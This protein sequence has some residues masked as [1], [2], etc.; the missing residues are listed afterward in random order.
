MGLDV[1][2]LAAAKK[3]TAQSLDGSGALQGQKGDPGK[4]G[5]D[6][7]II[8]NISVDEN[9]VL[10]TT[11]SDGT[12]LPSGT[13]QTVVGKDGVDGKDGIDGTNGTDGQDGITPHIDPVTKH[14]F[15]GT[16]DTGIVAEGKDGQDGQQGIPG[17]QGTPGVPGQQ[18]VQG[19]KGDKGDDGYPFLIYKEYADVSEFSEDD[20]PKIGLLFMIKVEDTTSFPV[21]RYTGE[22]ENPYSFVTNLSGSEGIK[23]DKGDPGKD[24]EQGIPGQAGAD[25][26]TYTPIIGTVTSLPSNQNPIASVSVDEENLTAKFNFSIPKGEKGEQGIP[27]KDGFIYEGGIVNNLTTTSEGFALD[28]RQGK[29]L[30]DK[31]KTR[32]VNW[33]TASINLNE[34]YGSDFVL[35]LI[36]MSHVAINGACSMYIASGISGNTYM[37][38]NPIVKI[39]NYAPKFSINGNILT[40]DFYD[41]N[42]GLYTVIPLF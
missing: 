6:A 9:N 4:D 29:I 22:T 33:K 7:P 17:Q 13:I 5:K 16:T 40:I 10:S 30:N 2:T 1:K 42:G 37:A 31:I 26:T 20:F 8:T 24:G 3:Y 27:G 18:G 38:V 15:T 25:G 23:G 35:L 14:W 32:F 19:V 34:Y 12:V 28:A 11:L 36:G 39:N 41:I 21:Y